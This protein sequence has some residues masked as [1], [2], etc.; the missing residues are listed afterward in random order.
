MKIIALQGK[1]KV[2]KT[3]TITRLVGLLLLEGAILRGTGRVGQEKMDRWYLLE[4]KNKKIGITTR[5]DSQKFLA[6]D[7]TN[8]KNCY[9]CVC[10]TH[11]IRGTVDFVKSQAKSDE[12]YWFTKMALKVENSDF[13]GN[14]ELEQMQDE[15]NKQQA[16]YMLDLINKNII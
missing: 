10:A 4:Y 1:E 5:G 12:I 11:T 2:G 14:Q 15:L 8:F 9:M 16:K 3:K 13:Q 7:F 6:E